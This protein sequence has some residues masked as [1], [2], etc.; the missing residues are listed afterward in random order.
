[1]ALDVN[2]YNAAFLGG[3][4][5]DGHCGLYFGMTQDPAENELC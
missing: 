5:D 3:D 1:M 2:G 4:K